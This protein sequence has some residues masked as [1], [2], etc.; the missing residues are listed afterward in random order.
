MPQNVWFK[1]S[2]WYSDSH[3]DDENNRDDE[4]EDEEDED[5]EDVIV[6][7]NSTSANTGYTANIVSRRWWKHNVEHQ[8]RERLFN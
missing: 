2:G 5:E 1:W 8:L 7:E 6:L 3:H 4:I